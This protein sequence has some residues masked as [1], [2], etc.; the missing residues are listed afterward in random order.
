MNVSGRVAISAPRPSE[1]I[2]L[3]H[4]APLRQA[5]DWGEPHLS[6]TTRDHELKHNLKFACLPGAHVRVV[7]EPNDLVT[8]KF[9][10]VLGAQ[11]GLRRLGAVELEALADALAQHI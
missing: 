2:K 1:R 5:T 10:V 4:D 11:V 9:A 3:G 6:Q 7:D 8:K